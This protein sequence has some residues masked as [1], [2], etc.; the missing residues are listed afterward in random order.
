M[1]LND[2]VANDVWK[3]ENQLKNEGSIYSPSQLSVYYNTFR[4]RFGTEAL[5]GL[6]GEALLETMHNNSNRDSLV[7]WLEFK[8]DEEF[9][10]IFGGIG[11]GSALKFGIYRRKENGVWMSGNARV[12]RELTL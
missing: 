1:I 2:K 7:Y 8:D 11:G 10:R 5:Q 6:D 3:V 4:R 9:P 12:Q